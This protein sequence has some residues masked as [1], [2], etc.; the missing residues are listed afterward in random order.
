MANDKLG[1]NGYLGW[2]QGLANQAQGFG[3]SILELQRQQQDAYYRAI[4][5]QHN[6]AFH[7]QS[8]PA[9]PK[10]DPLLVLL[11]EE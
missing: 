3:P 4:S 10:D 8:Q 9:P 7:A 5:N 1:L 11:T 6:A 2:N